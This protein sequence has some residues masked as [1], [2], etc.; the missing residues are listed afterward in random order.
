[1]ADSLYGTNN[2]GIEDIRGLGNFS[3][4]NNWKLRIIKLGNKADSCIDILG[5]VNPRCI[6]TSQPTK[7]INP[8]DVTIRGHTVG[9]PGDVTYGRTF[10]FTLIGTEDNRVE[11]F[12][13]EYFNL[14][15]EP[16]HLAQYSKQEI[17]CTAEF[18]RL[19]SMNEE[20]Y[21][22]TLVGAWLSN[23]TFPP[24]DATAAAMNISCT[25][26]YDYHKEESII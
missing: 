26:S 15:C 18:I 3:L 10:E 4:T 16:E 7:S 9:R 13:R 21:K 22:Y 24:G 19:N 14:C 17:E 25:F 1:M 5:E 23:A 8:V 6:S 12:A 11:N 20:I 2:V